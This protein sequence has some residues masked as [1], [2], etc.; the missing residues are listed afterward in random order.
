MPYF[1]I[2]KLFLIDSFDLT[3][4]EKED[5]ENYLNFL[6]ESDVGSIIEKQIK[7]NKSSGGRPSYD[8][9]KLFAG[10]AYGF[11]KCD[12]SL[13]K[14]EDFMKYDLRFLYINEQQRPSYSTISRF[15]NNYVVAFYKEIYISL[16]KKFIEKFNINIDDCFVDGTK[17][18]ANANKYKFIWKPTTFHKNLNLKILDL[19]DKYFEVDKEQK[20]TSSEVSQYLTSLGKYI[21]DEQ[22][23]INQ[24]GKGHKITKLDKDYYNLEN[25]LGKLLDYED[26]EEICGPYRNSFYKTDHDATAM[27]LK[28]DYYAGL[29]SNM[30]AAYNVQFIVSKG[31]ILDFIVSQERND[32]GAFIPLIDDFKYYFGYFPKNICADAGYGSINNYQYLNKNN[33]GNYV[34]YNMWEKQKNGSYY[35]LISFDEDGNL[36]CLNDKILRLCNKN[37]TNRHP[38][39]KSYLIYKV[40]NC[41]YCKFKAYCMNNLKDKKQKYRIFEISPIMI[42]FRKQARDNLLT[43]KGIEMRVNRSAQ[44]E[45][46]FGV[47]KQDMQFDRFRRK[48]LDNVSLEMMFICLGYLIRKLFSIY[49]GKGKFDYWIAPSDIKPEEF[50]KVVKGEK[51]IIKKHRTKSDNEKTK[52]KYKYQKIPK[53]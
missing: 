34:K 51:L 18:E 12:G 29:G 43:I 37:E 15:C 1:N 13:R 45:G 8:P 20:L 36:R 32:L 2:Q 27:C 41:R 53:K 26:K 4:K 17:I 22:G 38:K 23:K 44:V 5:L 24:N 25:Y 14:L 31:I 39:S 19:L 49:N 3:E 50:P 16:V 48:G 40:D 42:K 28:T 10:I 11:S 7:K 6:E 47:V 52:A 30:H 46:A 9:Y 35:E 33:I 21:I